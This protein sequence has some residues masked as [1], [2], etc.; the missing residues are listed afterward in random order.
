MDI[1]ALIIMF[2]MEGFETTSTVIASALALLAKHE[3]IQEDLRKEVLKA[4]PLGKEIT[5]EAINSVTLLQNCIT[6]LNR[7]RIGYELFTMSRI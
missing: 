3:E 7:T 6:G 2:F 5:E 1:L 4:C